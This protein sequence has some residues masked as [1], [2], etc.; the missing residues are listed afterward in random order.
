MNSNFGRECE[1]QHH[2]THRPN[3][4]HSADVD[5]TGEALSI[6]FNFV[7]EMAIKKA[8]TVVTSE[9]CGRGELDLQRGMV[10]RSSVKGPR[11]ASLVTGAPALEP[12]AATASPGRTIEVHFFAIGIC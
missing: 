2:C 10:L 7:S 5:V 4:E 11:E 6:F 12:P 3:W 9:E 8:G 1:C